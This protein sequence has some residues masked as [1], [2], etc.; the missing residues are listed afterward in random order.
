M[1]AVLS[2]RGVAANGVLAASYV[3]AALAFVSAL[4][5]TIFPQLGLMLPLVTGGRPSLI[6]LEQAELMLMAVGPLIWLALAATYLT[7]FKGRR[8]LALAGLP[9][10][11]YPAYVIFGALF[12]C[13]V[14]RI[15]P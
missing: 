15:C 13:S 11:A 14:M 5:V 3:V 7:A 8:I 4:S 2:G 12:S 1:T 9:L 10:A 6:P